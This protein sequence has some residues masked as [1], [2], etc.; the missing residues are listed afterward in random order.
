MLNGNSLYGFKNKDST[1]A[2]CFIYLA[3]FTATVATEVKSRSNAFKVYH[4]GTVFYFSTE[5]PEMVTT[6]IEMISAATLHNDPSKQPDEILYS[7]TD[8]SDSEKQKHSLIEKSTEP[9]KKFGSL[10]KF[11]SKKTN[12]D[13]NQGGSTSLDRKWFFNKSHNAKN[14]TPVPTAQFR[15]YRKIPSSNINE[16]SVSTGNFTSHIPNFAPRLELQTLSQSQNVSVPNLSIEPPKTPDVEKATRKIS[17]PL[18]KPSYI[19]ASNPSLCPNEF[20]PFIP[21]IRP[22][23]K[24]NLAGF[25][26][27][28]ELMN[29]QAEE[30][31][32]NP[33]WHD[34]FS[35]INP[36][37]IRPD[38]VYGEVPVRSK[39]K[40]EKPR[41]R[42]SRTASDCTDTKKEPRESSSC[43]GKRSGSMKKYPKE[44]YEPKP[45]VK[46]EKEA[47]EKSNG[48]L[49]RSQKNSDDNWISQN[50]QYSQDSDSCK[51]LSNIE[52]RSYEMIYCPQTVTDIQFAQNRFLDG[53]M[54]HDTPKRSNKIVRQHSL[55]S[56]D[57]KR[58][59]EE[60]SYLDSLKRCDKVGDKNASK[61]KLKSAIQYTPITLP[62]SPD[63]KGKFNPKFAFE[64]NLDEKPSKGGKLK[65]FFSK[66]ESKKEKSFLGSPKLHRAFFGKHNTSN[67]ADWPHSSQVRYKIISF[68]NTK[69]KIHCV[70]QKSS[71]LVTSSSFNAINTTEVSNEVPILHVSPPP[72][73]PGLEYPPVF[74]PETYSLADPHSSLTILRKQGKN[75]EN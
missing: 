6:W 55:N 37:L 48:S 20:I 64:L 71:S 29:R 49:S 50:K 47:D 75:N 60:R 51:S 15:S 43:F 40:E 67:E 69:L 73:Y 2:D 70:L 16:G 66:Q 27:L 62:L 8:E 53:R 12:G 44:S 72:D 17:M 19:H 58:I 23:V 33:H 28:E 22:P 56:A 59:N 57:K 36:N 31:K 74:E 21:K 42:H 13:S 54:Y 52:D 3:E 45:D 10:K 25:V 41:K 26:T 1:K 68:L 9:I 35:S 34:D 14:S 65:S 5:D 32:L 11:A 30:R 46:H 63:E 38:V 61:L 24:E 39:E 4:T 18:A 7:G